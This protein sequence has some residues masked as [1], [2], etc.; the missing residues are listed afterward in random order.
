MNL[1]FTFIAE[2]KGG[3]YTRQIEAKS[4]NAAISHWQKSEIALIAK[5][6]LTDVSNFNFDQ[7]DEA[8]SIDGCQNVWF[9]TSSVDKSFLLVNVVS[10]VA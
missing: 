4:L 8:V 3:T 10:T 5:A 1:L 7:L 6:S 9:S 2:Y